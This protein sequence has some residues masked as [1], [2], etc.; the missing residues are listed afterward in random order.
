[1]GPTPLVNFLRNVNFSVVSSNLD[2]SKEPKWPT[3]GNLFNKSMILDVGGEKIG[4]VGYI[5]KD[6]QWFV[7]YFNK[8][9]IPFNFF[10]YRKKICPITFSENLLY[11]E[12][13]V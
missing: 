9:D 5:T 2:V 6:S 1:M 10:I 7:S 8:L 12:M 13:G 4:F 11:Q 3:T